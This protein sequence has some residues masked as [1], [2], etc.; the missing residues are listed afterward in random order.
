MLG[1]E[2]DF[3]YCRIAKDGLPCFKVLDCWFERFP[4]EKFINDNYTDEEKKIIFTRPENKVSTLF[5]LIEKAKKNI[6]Q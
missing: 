5:D 1:H 2:V 6:G 4:V 3:S